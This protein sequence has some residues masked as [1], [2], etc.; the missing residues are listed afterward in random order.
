MHICCT[1]VFFFFTLDM[2]V[3]VC[4]VYSIFCTNEIVKIR[5]LLLTDMKYFIGIQI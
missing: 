4:L 3:I 2:I 1:N 5:K